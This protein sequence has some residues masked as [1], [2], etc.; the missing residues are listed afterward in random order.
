MTD[1]IFTDGKVL[2]GGVDV[3]KGISKIEVIADLETKMTEVGLFINPDLF[4]TMIPDAQP[5]LVMPEPDNLLFRRAADIVKALDP[6]E[7]EEAAL[8]GM[9]WGGNKNHTIAVLEKIVEVF[10]YAADELEADPEVRG[11]TDDGH[12]PDNPAE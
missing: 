5:T 11:S 1:I 7:I 4:T 10:E 9:Q 12:V 3:T 2:L 8:N 6:M